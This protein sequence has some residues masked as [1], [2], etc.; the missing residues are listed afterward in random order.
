MFLPLCGFI[1]MAKTFNYSE[2]KKLYGLTPYMFDPERI[3]VCA[4]EKEMTFEI[5]SSKAYLLF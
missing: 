1:E 4:L 5:S 2:S 3:K